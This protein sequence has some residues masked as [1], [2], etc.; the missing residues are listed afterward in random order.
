MYNAI[1]KKNNKIESDDDEYKEG[2]PYIRYWCGWA[3]YADKY[4]VEYINLQNKFLEWSLDD[5][6]TRE[7]FVV[8]RNRFLDLMSCTVPVLEARL[9]G[10]G[11]NEL[12]PCGSGKKFKKCCGKEYS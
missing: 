3:D 8:L 6:S 2:V 4:F 9:D 12:C 5:A 7:D 10:L 11:R 1:I